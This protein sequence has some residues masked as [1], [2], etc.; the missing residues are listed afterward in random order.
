MFGLAHFVSQTTLRPHPL[1]QRYSRGAG[2]PSFMVLKLAPAGRKVAQ[3]PPHLW[4][5]QSTRPTRSARKRGTV[6]G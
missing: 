1:R 2:S 5:K 4:H 3:S 6:S